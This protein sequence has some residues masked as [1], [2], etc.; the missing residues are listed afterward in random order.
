MSTCRLYF[1]LLLLL[2]LSLSAPFNFY[3]R[4]GEGVAH[5]THGP[6]SC[7]RHRD[8]GHKEES[9]ISR[10]PTASSVSRQIKEQSSSSEKEIHSC[11]KLISP[12]S[13]S[14][15]KK[16]TVKNGREQQYSRE[17]AKG[18][19]KKMLSLLNRKK[20]HSATAGALE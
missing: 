3:D 2:L 14:P 20:R 1:L 9:P 12:P 4:T 15:K 13:S 11:D 5:E 19:K 6:F 16:H 10:D 7:R 18:P 8:R 17:Q